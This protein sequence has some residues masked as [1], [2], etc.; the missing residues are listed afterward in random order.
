V[1][2]ACFFEQVVDALLSDDRSDA[3]TEGAERFAELM[4]RLKSRPPIATLAQS[5]DEAGFALT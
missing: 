4:E 2:R 1:Y 3:R 5:L